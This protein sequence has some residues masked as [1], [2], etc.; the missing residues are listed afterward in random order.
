MFNV[1]RLL[2]PRLAG[3]VDAMAPG[4]SGNPFAGL[5]THEL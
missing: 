1:Q 4:G 3:V 2:G 5:N